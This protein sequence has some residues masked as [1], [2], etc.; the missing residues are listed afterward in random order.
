VQSCPP[1]KGCRIHTQERER[2]FFARRSA[3]PKQTPLTGTN[4]TYLLGEGASNIFERKP[5]PFR[6]KG[7]TGLFYCRG[8]A[9][10]ATH[11]KAKI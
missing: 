1:G 4:G 2:K 7:R 10:A 8:S 6:P 3:S 11:A 9:R 5:P